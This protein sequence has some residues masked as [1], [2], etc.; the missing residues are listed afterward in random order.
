MT[1]GNEKIKVLTEEKEVVLENIK[2]IK[3]DLTSTEL[4]LEQEEVS[5]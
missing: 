1:L 3:N 2:Q 5:L 4:K